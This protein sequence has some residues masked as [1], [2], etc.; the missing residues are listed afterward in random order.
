MLALQHSNQLLVVPI[1]VV[2]EILTE[3]NGVEVLQKRVRHH[4]LVAL[5][6][7]LVPAT[8]YLLREGRKNRLSAQVVPVNLPKP[9]MQL[10]LVHPATTQPLVRLALDQ[11][12]DE[13]DA[14]PREIVGTELG[15][16]ISLPC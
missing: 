2:R 7:V 16:Q 3:A 6:V 1:V 8:L 13:V 14:L 10:Q 11:P 5:P 12:V 4:C 15:L 9:G